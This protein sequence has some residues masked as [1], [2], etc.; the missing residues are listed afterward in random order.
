[1]KKFLLFIAGILIVSLLI[2]GCSVRQK[3]ST[4]VLRLGNDVTEDYSTTVASKKMAEI[5]RDKTDGRIMIEVYPNSQLG[6]AKE[7]IDAVQMGAIQMASIGSLQMSEFNKEL[8][9]LEIPYLIRNQEHLDKVLGSD[10]GEQL[11]DMR[12]IGIVGLCFYDS[13]PRSFYNSKLPIKHPDDVRG[14]KIRSAPAPMAMD[15]LQALGALATPVPF[16]EVYNALQNKMVVGAEND[17]TSYYS[18]GHYEVAKY[19]TLNEHT[20]VPD[21]LIIS[22]AVWESLS[23]ADKEILHGAMKESKKLQKQLQQQKMSEAY[24]SLKKKGVVFVSI[25]DKKAWIDAARP[26]IDKHGKNYGDLIKRISSI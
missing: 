25:D 21:V 2:A 24:E 4:M 16:S 14:M 19:Y 13:A 8:R 20:R 1:M 23:E 6:D 26:V 7:L 15:M 9:V 12:N 10:I 3:K 18:K 22:E 5:V 11:L 17:I